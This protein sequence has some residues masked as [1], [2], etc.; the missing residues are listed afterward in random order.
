[1]TR[2][3][4]SAKKVPGFSLHKTLPLVVGILLLFSFLSCDTFRLPP[5][6]RFDSQG[7]S[8]ISDVIVQDGTRLTQPPDPTRASY[9]FAGWY[10]SRAF[11]QPYNFSLLVYNSFT[12]F[13]R[14]ELRDTPRVAVVEFFASPERPPLIADFTKTVHIGFPVSRPEQIPILEDFIFSGWYSIDPALEDPDASVP[15]YLQPDN[16][17]YPI[18]PGG[19]EPYNFNS[20][21]TSDLKLYALWL[22]VAVYDVTFNFCDDQSTPDVYHVQIGNPVARPTDPTAPSGSIVDGYDFGG[23]YL[24]EDYTSPFDFNSPITKDTDL[25]ARWYP[26][27]PTPFI[28]TFNYLDGSSTPTTE[29]VFPNHMAIRPTDP[30]WDRPH[31][32]VNWYTVDPTN[33]GDVAPGDSGYP[34]FPSG[35]SPYNF[36]TPVTANLDLYAM[37]DELKPFTITFHTGSGSTG[38]IDIDIGGSSISPITITSG[39]AVLQLYDTEVISVPVP[40]SFNR[41]YETGTH[42]VTPVSPIPTPPQWGTPG[43][44]SFRGWYTDNKT[45]L[46]RF[47]FNTPISGDFN[48]Y[49]KWLPHYMVDIAGG[50]FMMGSAR[51]DWEALVSEM[52]QHRVIVSDFVMAGVTVTRELWLYVMNHTDFMALPDSTYWLPS[53]SN[54]S[55]PPNANWDRESY[56]GEIRSI[57]YLPVETVSWYWALVFCNRLSILDGLEPVYTISNSR[58]PDVWGRIPTGTSTVWNRVLV[59]REASGYRLPTEAEWEYACRAGT[60]TGFSNNS[61]SLNPQDHISPE[62]NYNTTPRPSSITTPVGTYPANPWGFFDMHG[63]VWEWCFDWFNEKDYYA[64]SP[65]RDPQGPESSGTSGGTR[66]MRGGSHRSEMRDIR[67]ANRW[68]HI[69]PYTVNTNGQTDFQ[70]LRIVVNSDR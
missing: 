28:V 61:N 4:L 23:W 44:Y 66:V 43:Q 67:S 30:V 9:V 14:W 19:T 62:A 22:P 21:V 18:L 31:S 57:S 49:A 55:I 32:F 11:D 6:V 54:R 53:Q 42:A 40:A 46:N 5:V 70:G 48:L 20:A 64:N 56:L 45:F 26:G 15:V 27:A 17:V 63:N 47:D 59:D 41:P 13:A 52:P 37:W 69:P 33:G 25:Y 51:D 58:D 1:M 68:R 39:Q 65:L 60:T 35:T 7:G 2:E 34:A 36:S 12:L 16:P 10:T 50:E 29:S 8:H 24:D 3:M 38:S